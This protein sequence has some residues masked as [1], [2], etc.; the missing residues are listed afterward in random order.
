MPDTT[1]PLVVANENE[2]GRTIED[3]DTLPELLQYIANHLAANAGP[4]T[5][6][7]EEIPFTISG[8][9]KEET[10]SNKVQFISGHPS[11]IAFDGDKYYPYPP[12]VAFVHIGND[13]PSYLDALTGQEVEDYG[14]QELSGDARWLI[15]R[16]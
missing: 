13:Y 4:I 9:Q 16:P 11:Y 10:C 8:S 15:L 14:L 3:I 1:L 12:N 2:Q 6:L 5:S 7:I